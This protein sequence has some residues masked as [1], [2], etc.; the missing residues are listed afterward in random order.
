MVKATGKTQVPRG[1]Y[2]VN[3]RVKAIGAESKVIGDNCYFV[4]QGELG[5]ACTSS[6]VIVG[7]PQCTT[8][9]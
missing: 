3:G 4:N 8:I 5:K 9:A 2:P 1:D 7:S 6:I